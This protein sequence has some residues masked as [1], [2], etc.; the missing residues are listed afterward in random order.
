MPQ[1]EDRYILRMEKISKYFMGVKALHEVN[2]YVKQGEVHALMGEN[3]AGK[4]TLMKILAGIYQKDEGGIFINGHILNIDNPKTALDSGIS[5]IHQELNPVVNMTVAENI[6]LGKEPCYGRTGIINKRKQK[7]QAML[8]FEEMGIS[9]NPNSKINNLSIAEI[10]MVEIV[11]AVSY[12][13]RIIIMDEPTSA[14][15]EKEIGKLFEIIK[16]LKAKGVAIIYISH[17][18]D[19]IFQISDTITVLRDGEYIDTRPANELNNASLITL[20]VGRNITELFPKEIPSIGKAVLEID[21]FSKKGFFQHVSFK[22]YEGEIVGFAGLLGAG[23]TELMEAVFGITRPDSGQLKINNKKAV[24]RS[25]ADAVKYGLALITD[26]RK[27]KGLNLKGSVKTNVSLLSLRK[28]CKMLQVINQKKENQAVDGQIKILDIKVFGRNQLAGTM[29]G[30]NQQKVVLAKWFLTDP[31]IL[32][33]DEP[34]RGIDIGAK[35]EIYKIVSRLA[36]QGKTVLLVSSEMP[37]LLG[38]C[39]RIIVLHNGDVTGVF[40]RGEFNSELIMSA[41][42]GHNPKQEY[43]N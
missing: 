14:I 41:A 38:L 42:M 23:R 25:P 30:G 29:S 18:M 43:K 19:E 37:E 4:S 35:Q 1:I 28:Y 32:I 17:K 9:V 10:Q 11:K 16:S 20:M 6:Y 5:M 7:K 27:L 40:H 33:L 36:H 34:T 15:S 13:A 22:V 12:N 2:L 8:L 21:G 39:D 31:Q 3:G 24:I 26:D